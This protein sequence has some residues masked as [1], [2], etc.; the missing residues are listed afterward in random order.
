MKDDH[1]VSVS[2]QKKG[3]GLSSHYKIEMYKSHIGWKV[4]LNHH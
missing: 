4:G 1:L 3:E 2:I